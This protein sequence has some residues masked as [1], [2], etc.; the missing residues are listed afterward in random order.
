MFENYRDIALLQSSQNCSGYFNI[1]DVETLFELK[2]SAQGITWRYGMNPHPDLELGF[3]PSRQLKNVS[4]SDTTT[5]LGYM[6]T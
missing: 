5:D 2:E 3:I 4:W 1:I 6:Q